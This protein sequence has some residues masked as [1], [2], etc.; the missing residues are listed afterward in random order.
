MAIL[1]AGL[2]V[3]AVPAEAEVLAVQVAAE[4]VAEDT[5][6]AEEADHFV[7]AEAQVA[8]AV[9]ME[10]TTAAGMVAV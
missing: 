7:T 6:Q 8:A 10:V 4:A 5:E 3:T 2:L 1:Q 9:V